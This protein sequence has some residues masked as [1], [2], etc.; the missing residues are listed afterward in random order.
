MVVEV[1]VDSADGTSC[2][3]LS[4]FSLCELPQTI[5]APEDITMSSFSYITLTLRMCARYLIY[6]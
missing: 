1:N 6:M 3:H 4:L 2:A 5:T